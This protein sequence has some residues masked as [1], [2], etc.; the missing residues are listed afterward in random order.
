MSKQPKRK[1]TRP[2]PDE[3]TRVSNFFPS[4]D[5]YRV[6]LFLSGQGDPVSFQEM[7]DVVTGDLRGI[8]RSLMS[9]GFISTV[10]RCS[11]VNYQLTLRGHRLA[12]AVDPEK[13]ELKP[14][15]KVPGRPTVCAE[16]KYNWRYLWVF[17]IMGSHARAEARE[18]EISVK[19]A[20]RTVEK[21]QPR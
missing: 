16:C 13:L 18:R 11:Q 15:R 7:R 9:A 10:Q 21:S 14:G 8:I 6:L 3:F 19:P 12:D 1:L 5:K 2:T 4:P 17:Q 20:P